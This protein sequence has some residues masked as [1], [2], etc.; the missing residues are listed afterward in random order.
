MVRTRLLALAFQCTLLL[1]CIHGDKHT[2]AAASTTP[3]QLWAAPAAGGG[4]HGYDGWG[5][6]ESDDD[7]THRDQPVRG[8]GQARDAVRTALATTG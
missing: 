8:L 1:C 3:I 6:D 7:G 5:G 2:A 4:Q